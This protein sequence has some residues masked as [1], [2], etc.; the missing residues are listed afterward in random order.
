P[1]RLQVAQRVRADPHVGPGWRDR[2]GADASDRLVVL[3]RFA[4]RPRV[5]EAATTALPPDPRTVARHPSQPRHRAEGVARWTHGQTT[6]RGVD[7]GPR[8]TYLR[9]HTDERGGGTPW[10]HSRC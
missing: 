9:R 7:L 2:E 5:R 1:R 8:G 3:D 6:D 4:A 10:T